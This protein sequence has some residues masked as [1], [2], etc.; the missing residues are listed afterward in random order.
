MFLTTYVNDVD[1]V[2]AAY[3][4]FLVHSRFGPA[5]PLDG[6]DIFEENEATSPAVPFR[7]DLRVPVI[8]VITETDLIGG[9]RVG[10]HAA[11][12][13]DNE[14]SAGVGDPRHR[15][16]RQLHDPGR[17]HRQRIGAAGTDSSRRT[18]LPTS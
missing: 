6:T 16:R 14:H 15:A 4:G 7:A 11:R 2:A 5:A 17:L 10:Y 13:P 18:H 3:D 1:P 9:C 8:T 12:Q